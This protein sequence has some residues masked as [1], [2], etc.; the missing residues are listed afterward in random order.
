MRPF[1]GLLESWPVPSGVEQLHMRELMGHL[2]LEN[3]VLEGIVT[4]LGH[5]TSHGLSWRVV[6]FSFL[7]LA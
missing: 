3:Q 2:E 6:F 1:A 4:T 7:P 5:N